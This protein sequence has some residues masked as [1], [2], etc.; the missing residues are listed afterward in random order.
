MMLLPDIEHRLI[1]HLL[2]VP[3]LEDIVDNRIYAELPPNVVYPCVTVKIISSRSAHPRWLEAGTFEV[4]G[5]SNRQFSG[6]R[7][8]ARDTCET[9]VSALHSLVNTVIGDVVVVGPVATTGPRPVPDQ[10]S[11]G[12]TNPRFIAEVSMTYHPA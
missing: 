11:A 2:T 5:W 1:E 10:I 8:L 4:A 12:V 3:D 6:A 9:A 7:R